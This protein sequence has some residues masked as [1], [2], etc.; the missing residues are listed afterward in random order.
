MGV[1]GWDLGKVFVLLLEGSKRDA[2]V[3]DGKKHPENT[4]TFPENSLTSP[5]LLTFRVFFPIPFAGI[6][7]GP[8]S[9]RNPKGDGRKGTGQK[10]S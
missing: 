1:I 10:M 3:A 7:C 2:H 8:F 4:L 9:R 5:I 6:P